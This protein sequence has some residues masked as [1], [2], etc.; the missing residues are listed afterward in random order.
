MAG[1]I[2]EFI[3]K[4]GKNP[5]IGISVPDKWDE[6][7]KAVKMLKDADSAELFFLPM[8][9]EGGREAHVNPELFGRDIANFPSRYGDIP[10][11]SDYLDSVI[12]LVHMTEVP[13]RK[14]YMEEIV[15]IIKPDGRLMIVD[16]GRFD[17]YLL[18]E[19]FDRNL[20]IES[21]RGVPVEPDLLT[22]DAMQ[23]IDDPEIDVVA[24]MT[25]PH[26][27]RRFQV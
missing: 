20:D 19:I 1:R 22:T 8:S 14:Q 13:N 11:K 3:D 21:D 18:E 27:I 23:V 16:F 6:L 5:K 25:N 10:L 17:S 4:G 12:S 26:L 2:A 24:L 15:R 9:A 7:H